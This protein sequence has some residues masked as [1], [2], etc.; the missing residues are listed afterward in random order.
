MQEFFMTITL[1]NSTFSLNFA[2]FSPKLR[3]GFKRKILNR[4]HNHKSVSAVCPKRFFRFV[5]MPFPRCAVV[6]QQ[7]EK[8]GILPPFSLSSVL[9]PPNHT[10]VLRILK[11]VIFQNMYFW[12]E[13]CFILIAQCLCFSSRTSQDWF[14]TWPSFWSTGRPQQVGSCSF[15]KQ[16][17]LSFAYLTNK[18][19]S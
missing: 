12:P 16:Q 10:I 2:I 11:F 9:S 18:F 5:K 4:L 13:V 17:Q 7:L 19:I 8:L 1:F 6:L 3:L 15:Q 14:S